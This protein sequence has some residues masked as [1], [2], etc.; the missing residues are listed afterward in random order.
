M[1]EQQYGFHE[2]YKSFG[3]LILFHFGASAAAF[4]LYSNLFPAK[5]EHFTH[6]IKPEAQQN[7]L[8]ILK[9]WEE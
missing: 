2:E 9:C 5:F 6:F 4:L 1:S 8:L 3:W 7:M